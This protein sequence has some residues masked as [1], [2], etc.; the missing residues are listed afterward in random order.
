[1]VS[2]RSNGIDR[3][4]FS[5]VGLILLAFAAALA[6]GAAFIG[7]GLSKDAEYQREADAN[8]R[9][10]AAYADQKERNRCIG[11]SSQKEADCVA[12]YSEEKRTNQRYE[13]DLVAQRQSANWAY[14]MGAAAVIGM[15]LSVVGVVLVWTTFDETRKAN[16]ITREHQRARILPSAELARDF[17]SETQKAILRC[18]NIGLSAAYRV[19][20]FA[21][22]AKEAPKSPPIEADFGYERTIIVGEKVD[23]IVIDPF[24]NDNYVC[25]MIQYDTIF[26]GPQKSYFCF[27]FDW[28][29][30]SKKWFAVSKIPDTWPR[31]T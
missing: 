12:E 30:Q 31:D 18:E 1:M 2:D 24:E 29:Q 14:I 4:K 16:D 10:Y 8:A 21:L 27:G 15:I 17:H 9:E 7:L 5:K 19:K 20:C 26:V 28:S 6:L 11:F 13:Q 23:F 25:G 3:G 22:T